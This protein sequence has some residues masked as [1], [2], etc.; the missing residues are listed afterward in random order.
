[1]SEANIYERL[2]RVEA[3]VRWIKDKLAERLGVRQSPVED[4]RLLRTIRLPDG[5]EAV[6][7]PSSLGPRSD[8]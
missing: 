6:V 2:A 5:R 1:M 3:E 4:E 7:V 8:K